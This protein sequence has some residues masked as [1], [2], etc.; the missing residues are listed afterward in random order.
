MLRLLPK[1]VVNYIYTMIH[2]YNICNVIREY[3]SRLV[4]VE[5]A[6]RFHY[7]CIN[8][9]PKSMDYQYSC[10]CQYNYRHI[11]SYNFIS[12]S[13]VYNVHGSKCAI[14]PERYIYSLNLKY[15][16]FMHNK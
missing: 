5:S 11:E 14:L 7:V 2:E 16:Y 12:M 4:S 15:D 13:S 3:Q 9:P 8:L 10:N 6:T 1:D